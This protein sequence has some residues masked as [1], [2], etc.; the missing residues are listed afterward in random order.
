MNSHI[1]VLAEQLWRYQG[2][3]MAFD[4]D[5]IGDKSSKDE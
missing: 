2:L 1:Q 4:P 5:D 3:V